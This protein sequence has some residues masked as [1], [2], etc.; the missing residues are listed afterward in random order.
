MFFFVLIF[1]TDRARAA[2][3]VYMY[4]RAQRWRRSHC[5]AAYVRVYVFARRTPKKEKYVARSL[6]VEKTAG[7]SVRARDTK[8]RKKK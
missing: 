7:D 8:K 1:G 6:A 5:L 2:V 3:D 4:A